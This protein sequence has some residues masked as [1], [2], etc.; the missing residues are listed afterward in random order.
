MV[1]VVGLVSA[2]PSFR[3][4]SFALSVAYP[5]LC[6][7]P[8]SSLCIP[9]ERLKNCIK[10]VQSFSIKVAEAERAAQ[11]EAKRFREFVKWMKYG[12]SAGFALRIDIKKA[13]L[14]I[15]ICRDRK[16]YIRSWRRRA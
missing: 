11:E 14:A 7:K 1:N 9:K 15:G 3:G 10:Q 5:R 12:K 13:H 8:A 6:S 16:E 2:S 4:R